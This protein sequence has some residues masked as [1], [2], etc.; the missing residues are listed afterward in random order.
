M[1]LHRWVEAPVM[2]AGRRVAARRA[3]VA[4]G[5]AFWRA[6][7]KARHALRPA[8]RRHSREVGTDH[9]GC[10]ARRRQFPGKAQVA[11]KLAKSSARAAS[12]PPVQKPG[13]GQGLDGICA[14]TPPQ[15]GKA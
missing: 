12:S 1:L 8:V 14:V 6:V 10:R 15:R 11:A 9:Y 3:R 13:E 5:H 2:A 7:D 4:S